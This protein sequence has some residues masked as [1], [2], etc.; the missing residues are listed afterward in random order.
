MA[1]TPMTSTH[2][3]PPQSQPEEAEAAA[4]KEKEKADADIVSR[5]LALNCSCNS[6]CQ[7]KGTVSTRKDHRSSHQLNAENPQAEA[8]KRNS[9]RKEQEL[10]GICTAA[11]QLPPNDVSGAEPTKS[12]SGVTATVLGYRSPLIS[13]DQFDVAMQYRRPRPAVGG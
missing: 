3:C 8:L 10:S 13:N 12:S 7:G 4:A 6:D 9:I 5:K 2:R 1:I 11:R